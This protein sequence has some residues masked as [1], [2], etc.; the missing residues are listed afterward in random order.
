[1]LREHFKAPCEAVGIKIHDLPEVI[2]A[3][4]TSNLFGCV[5]EDML[6]TEFADGGNVVDDYLKRRG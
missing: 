6:A 1:M 3:D 4:A 2:G 5:F